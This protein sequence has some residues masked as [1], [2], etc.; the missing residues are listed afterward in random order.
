[1]ESSQ[2]IHNFF[3]CFKGTSSHPGRIRNDCATRL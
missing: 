2:N 3:Q 1:M